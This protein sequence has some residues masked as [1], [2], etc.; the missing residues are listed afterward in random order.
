MAVLWQQHLNRTHYKVTQAGNSLRLYRD[1]IFHSQFNEQ[2]LVSGAVWDLLLLPA[3]FLPSQQVR[4]V[5]VL[6]VGGGAVMRML[7]HCFP[8]AEIHGVEKDP[9]H[10]DVAQNWFGV[11]G[12]KITLHEHC[13][14]QW[15]EQFSG[16]PFD[17]IIDD[18]F[19]GL[20]SDPERAIMVDEDWVALL[21]N[22]K[23]KNGVLAF[24]FDTTQK[25]HGSV[26]SNKSA[27]K[28]LGLINKKSLTTEGFLNQIVVASEASLNENDFASRL[29]K[30]KAL[31][32]D[33]RGCRLR[34][35]VWSF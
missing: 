29:K 13:A 27:C 21:N 19:G 35:S 11:Q 3:F 6:G 34:H 9:V 12:E 10:L 33:Y 18:V 23:R 5:L 2:T 28:R 25:A 8:E 1:G 31:N 24:N 4:R 30:I 16:E 26:L 20:K 7:M 32:A 15:V 14:K 17:V 22:M